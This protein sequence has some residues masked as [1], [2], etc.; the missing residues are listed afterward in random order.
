MTNSLETK[1]EK[2]WHYVFCRYIVRNGVRIYHP[3]G[4]VFRFRVAD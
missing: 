2:Q 1:N 4:K 3:K